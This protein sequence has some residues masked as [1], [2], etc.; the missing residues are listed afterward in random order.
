MDKTS[1]KIISLKK[2]F[3]FNTI[4]DKK[5]QVYI[6]FKTFLGTFIIDEMYTTILGTKYI[7][8]N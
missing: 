7:F 4:Y 2:L 1:F 3:F 8:K 6:Y 5:N